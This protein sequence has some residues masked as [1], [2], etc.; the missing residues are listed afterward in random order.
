MAQ[1]NLYVP[2]DLEA[3]IKKKAKTQGKSVSSFVLEAVRDKIVPSKWS[4]EFL[5]LL[6]SDSADFPDVEDGVRG[7]AFVEAVV[8][9]S[10]STKKW[11][12]VKY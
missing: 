12:P 9:S 3:L 6:E 1:V 10:G 5:S 11:T 8:K 2:D 4:R 7:M